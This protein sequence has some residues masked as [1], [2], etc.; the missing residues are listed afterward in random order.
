M[1]EI[2]CCCSGKALL[3]LLSSL[4]SMSIKGLESSVWNGMRGDVEGDVSLCER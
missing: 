2:C 1:V 4:N 3:L